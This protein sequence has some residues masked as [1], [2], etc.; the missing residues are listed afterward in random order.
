MNYF[1]ILF[2][3]ILFFHSLFS[4]SVNQ[5]DNSSQISEEEIQI[6][7]ELEQ[8][9]QKKERLKERK[10]LLSKKKENLDNSKKEKPL[11]VKEDLPIKKETATKVNE[12]DFFKLEEDI[13][14]TA[15]RKEEKVTEA[16]ATIYVI[17]EKQ[18][19]ERGYRTLVDA[20]HDVPGFDIIH[21]YGLFP[22]LIHQR[23]LVGNNQRSI[24]YIDGIPDNNLTENAML[25]GSIRFPLNNVQRIEIVSGP[26][27]AL[28]GANAFNGIIN[29]ITR[30]GKKN[31]GN[32][33]DVTYGA[34]ES[35]FR[36][37]GAGL[38]FSSRGSGKDLQDFQY[39]VGGYYYQT[40][41][42]DFGGIGRLDKKNPNPYDSNY[43][44]ESKA[45]GGVCKPDA[46]SVGYFWPRKFNVANVETY[47][48][49]GKFSYKNFRFETINW[50]F[51]MGEGTVENGTY[52][53]H[54]KEPGLETNQYDSRNWARRAGI[55]LGV[56]GPQ[57]F[58]GSSWDF[59]NN[60]STVGYTH[61]FNKKINL[62]SEFITR[63]TELLSSSHEEYTNTPG[64]NI[65]YKPGD[66]TRQN[67]YSRPDQSYELREKF[68]WE[69]SNKSSTTI[70]IE[71][72][73]VTVPEAYG[74]DR[75]FRYNN[76]ANYIQQVYKPFS[77]LH[78]T[79]G[80]RY[81]ENTIY[82]ATR[83]PRLGLI[84]QIA[85]NLN[86][87]FLLG[88][89]FR[90]PTAWELFNKTNARKANPG[91]RPEKM[92]S[93]E[94]GFGYRFSERYYI[95]INGYYNN[96]TDLIIQLETNEYNPN[97]PGAFWTQNQNVGAAKVYGSEISTDFQFTS[98]LKLF[99]SYTHSQGE[100]YSMYG[101]ASSPSTRGRVGDE[102][103]N[104]VLGNQIG[105]SIVPQTGKMP[106]IAPNKLSA[107][108]TYHLL[109][110]ISIHTGLN[111]V[112]VRRTIATN[113]ERAVPAYKMLHLNFRWEDFFI[114]GMFLQIQVHNAFN[115]LNFDPGIRTATGGYYPTMI[116]LEKRN[117]WFTVGYKF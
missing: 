70:G 109:A 57:G 72:L 62:D 55:A 26:A 51:L 74:S 1:V 86:F 104:D 81:D 63:H 29:I 44:L 83:N 64:P 113:P 112:D 15:S 24:V 107:G 91:L 110:N 85:K 115:D 79:A 23:G 88:T 12:E 28:Y 41:G 52:A 103:F 45:C 40:A 48:M 21:T 66:V 7:K 73:S 20:L 58:S 30:D 69:Q 2:C 82:G 36:N 117:I 8:L 50:Q 32:H 47:N 59:R 53:V 25:G 43:A 27:S 78:F 17:T 6:Q 75:R 101:F 102:G 14:V 9:E 38:S 33:V 34:Y 106:N 65:N 114:V 76:Y 80:L 97:I 35:N 4:Q 111:Y 54:L 39:S 90:A 71:A 31:P 108:I 68:Q 10:Y 105:K 42:P 60:S 116:P 89:G 67:N 19:R 100:Y 84:W 3:M 93:V 22:E 96:I 95:H 87:K 56:V 94:I 46:N 99:M 11:E 16:P 98:Y 5:E 61:Q 18:I 77:S 92:R 37:P 49:T 13:V